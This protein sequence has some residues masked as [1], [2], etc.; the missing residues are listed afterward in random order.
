VLHK[1]ILTVTT[2]NIIAWTGGQNPLQVLMKVTIAA[3]HEVTKFSI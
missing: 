3:R 2:Y 1:T